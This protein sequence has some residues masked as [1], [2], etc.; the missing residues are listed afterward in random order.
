MVV[1]VKDMFTDIRPADAGQAAGAGERQ[2]V[3]GR[4]MEE[5]WAEARGRQNWLRA[6]TAAADFDD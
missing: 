6:R 1:H 5:V 2:P 4:T 3:D